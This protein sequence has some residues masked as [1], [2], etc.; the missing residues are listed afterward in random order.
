MSD[1]KPKTSFENFKVEIDPE[2]IDESVRNLSE[3]LGQLVEQGRHMKVRLKYKGKPL[4]K[5]IPLPVLAAAQLAGFWYAG[6]MQA[7]VLN[8][9]VKAFLEVEF[10]HEADGLVLEGQ[11]RYAEGE[12][13]A[14]EALYREALRMKPGDAAAHY[15]LGVLLRVTGR[16]DE[17]IA[18]LSKAA[19]VAGHPDAARAQ[20]ALDRLQR[21]GKTL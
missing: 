11:Q 14:A 21:P 17:A 12:V 3:R 1:E 4:M 5:D 7:I 16:R 9:G 6:L 19:A 18:S 15:H 2:K 8:L 20:E 10:I 13:E